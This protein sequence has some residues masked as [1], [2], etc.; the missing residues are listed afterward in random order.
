MPDGT[1]LI[2]HLAAQAL[3]LCLARE[4]GT[5]KF[6]IPIIMRLQLFQY[7]SKGEVALRQA[8][9]PK[10]SQGPF[11]RQGDKKA[12]S[13]QTVGSS[14]LRLTLYVRQ[15]KPFSLSLKLT[16]LEAIGKDDEAFA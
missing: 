2:A 5:S 12:Q 8:I 7:R 4:A 14:G 15:V 1:S 3:L 6:Y 16:G 11:P 13:L 10:A 9:R